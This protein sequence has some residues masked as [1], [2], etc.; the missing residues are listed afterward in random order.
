MVSGVAINGRSREL[1]ILLGIRTGQPADEACADG[2]HSAEQADM[3]NRPDTRSRSAR[4]RRACWFSLI[5]LA[6]CNSATAPP[7]SQQQ[8]LEA[9]LDESRSVSSQ[10]HVALALA[11]PQ[12]RPLI[13]LPQV[14]AR[15]DIAMM[16]ATDELNPAIDALRAA[17]YDR[18]EIAT[19]ITVAGAYNSGNPADS[20]AARQVELRAKTLE[21]FE[22]LDRAI[23]EL[24][25]RSGSVVDRRALVDKAYRLEPAVLR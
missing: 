7:P 1:S 4:R 17:G 25:A 9:E 14:Q 3:Q 16:S 5:L 11:E 18:E 22:T 2:M 20:A 8:R 10:D 23:S 6:G 13:T 24:E 19:M 21:G 15:I 12:P